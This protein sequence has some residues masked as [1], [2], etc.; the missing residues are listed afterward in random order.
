MMASFSIQLLLLFT[1]FPDLDADILEI[2]SMEL[3]RRFTFV[4]ID[5]HCSPLFS[6]SMKLY[7]LCRSLLVHVLLA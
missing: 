4:S 2:F 7:F 3:E 5:L 6:V 1:S